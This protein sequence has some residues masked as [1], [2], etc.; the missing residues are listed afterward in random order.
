[1]DANS[2]KELFGV[3]CDVSEDFIHKDILRSLEEEIKNQI[4]YN[5]DTLTAAS[6]PEFEAT[7]NGQNL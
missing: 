5:N 1:M 7:A 2:F 4:S 6:H 3:V